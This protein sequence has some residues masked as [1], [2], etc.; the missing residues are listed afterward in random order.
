MDRTGGDAVG[1]RQ[2]VAPV[3]RRGHRVD[4]PTRGD[5]TEITAAGAAPLVRYAVAS[6]RGLGRR[7]PGSPGRVAVGHPAQTTAEAAVLAIS[8]T[9]PKAGSN[10]TVITAA[11]AMAAY[12]PV[13]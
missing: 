3:Q 2:P 11:T 5:G 10:R 13:G 1:Q 12:S 4:A 9:G 6:R 8:A 7:A